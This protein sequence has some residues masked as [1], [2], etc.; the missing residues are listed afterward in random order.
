MNLPLAR[1][2]RGTQQ[3]WLHDRMSPPPEGAPAPLAAPPAPPP[4]T[5][6]A[7]APTTPGASAAAAPAA[8]QTF[9]M[10]GAPPA[11]PTPTA[12]PA[13]ETPAS[14]FDVTKATRRDFWRADDAVQYLRFWQHDAAA[15]RELRTVL[16]RL[17][18]S[19]WVFAHTDD[20]V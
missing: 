5:T 7:A 2:R 1:L 19:T 9:R 8:T 14:V 10:M 11:A 17:E 16:Q 6:P 20:R 13:A 12:T 15:C 4:A 18:P 3:V